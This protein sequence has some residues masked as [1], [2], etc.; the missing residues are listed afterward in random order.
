MRSATAPSPSFEKRGT[1]RARAAARS[2]GSASRST[3]GTRSRRQNS[4]PTQA[5]TDSRCVASKATDSALGLVVV[6]WPQNA[7]ATTTPAASSAAAQRSPRPPED[8]PAGASPA[9][10]SALAAM[11]PTDRAGPTAAPAEAEAADGDGSWPLGRQRIK[12]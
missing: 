10:V 7:G 11:A 12:G 3:R 1:V 4:P 6:A 5:D 2:P 9:S 8:A